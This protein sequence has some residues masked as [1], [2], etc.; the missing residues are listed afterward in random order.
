MAT[1]SAKIGRRV[2][3][4]GLLGTALALT[5][6]SAGPALAAGRDPRSLPPNPTVSPNPI[7][8]QTIQ[9]GQQP[10]STVTLNPQPLPPKQF[11][12]S[13]FGR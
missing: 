1:N 6:F 8:L 4:A 13:L 7:T 10:G 9:Q 5:A 11:Q 3:M 12:R 2:V